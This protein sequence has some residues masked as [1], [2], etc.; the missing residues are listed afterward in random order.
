MKDEKLKGDQVINGYHYSFDE[1][2][3]RQRTGL[4]T[5]A[6]GETRFYEAS[7]RH[8]RGRLQTGGKTYYFQDPDGTAV[9]NR[10]IICPDGFAGYFGA[11]KTALTSPFVRDGITFHPDS[12]GNIIRV[13]YTG[14]AC[15]SQ[16]DPLW[17]NIWINGYRFQGTGCVP[18]VMASII[19]R[20]TSSS[21][22]PGELGRLL[23]SHRLMNSAGIGSCG[24]SM[25]F[26][27]RW[28]N[29][30][31][32]GSLSQ[33][34][35]AAILKAGGLLAAAMDPGIFSN[36]PYTHEIL[37]YGYDNGMVHVHDPYWPEHSGIYSLSVIFSQLSSDPDDH[38]A[39]GPVFGFLNPY[40]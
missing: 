6:K 2:T 24:D 12:T 4:H 38:A 27:G 14:L 29:L 40:V 18:T 8:A 20:L 28:Y 31:A 10:M 30:P 25:P 35:A 23:G 11:G 19:N 9:S 37:I 33:N 26:L 21:V 13:D 34:Q 22:T 3:G 7:G 36:P 1:T 39:G 16:K 32:H 15:Y 5:N 17:A